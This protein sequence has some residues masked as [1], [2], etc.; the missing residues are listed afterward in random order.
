MPTDFSFSTDTVLLTID[1]DDD[2]G[3]TILKIW[4]IKTLLGPPISSMGIWAC[5]QLGGL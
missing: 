1:D 4:T 2:D 3:S 5:T